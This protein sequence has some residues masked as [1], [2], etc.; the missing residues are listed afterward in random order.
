[1]QWTIHSLEYSVLDCFWRAVVFN[2][3]SYRNMIV[4]QCPRN[5][6]IRTPKIGDQV[7]FFRES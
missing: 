2:G 6:G 5:D 4:Y 3:Y 7:K 1:M